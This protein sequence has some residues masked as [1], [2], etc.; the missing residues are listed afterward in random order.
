VK[1]DSQLSKAIKAEIECIKQS[2]ESVQE[3]NN[4]MKEAEE[5]TDKMNE[6]WQ[7]KIQ[8]HDFMEDIITLHVFQNNVGK[9]VEQLS[10]FIDMETEMQTLEKMA[11]DETKYLIVGNKLLNLIELRDALLDDSAWQR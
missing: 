4:F 7:E 11:E 5:Q 1:L 3:A 10:Y 9:V 8:F 6:L 2:K